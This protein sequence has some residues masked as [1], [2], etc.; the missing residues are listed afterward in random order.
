MYGEIYP[1]EEPG[2]QPEQFDL[3]EPFVPDPS[4]PVIGS[5]STADNADETGSGETPYEDDVNTEG[6]GVDETVTAEEDDT[7][8]PG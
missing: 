5:E 1:A 6:I 2:W 4:L 8:S 7:A 3:N